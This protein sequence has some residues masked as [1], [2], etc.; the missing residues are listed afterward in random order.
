[1]YSTNGVFGQVRLYRLLEPVREPALFTF[2]SMGWHC[3]NDQYRISRPSGANEP[4]LLFTVKGE[5]CLQIKK[6][7]Y[8]LQAGS[9]ALVPRNEPNSYGTPSGETWE[10]YWIHPCGAAID[11]LDKVTEQGGFMMSFLPGYAYRQKLEDLLALCA[12]RPLH[13]EWQLSQQLSALLHHIALGMWTEYAQTTLAQR[14]VAY[15]EN[16]YAEKIIL[17]QLAQQLYV[18]T[19]HLIRVFRREIGCTPHQYLSQ[20]RLMTAEHLLEFS[21]DPIETIALETGFSSSSHFISQFRQTHG[22]TPIQ[23]RRRFSLQ[24]DIL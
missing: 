16:H 7:E 9:I 17:D 23:F 24:D 11:F 22:L 5:G 2:S 12:E 15:L 19:A 4:L 14:A 1:M 13:F 10:F 21:N 20:Y 18:S 6:R 3:C 8:R